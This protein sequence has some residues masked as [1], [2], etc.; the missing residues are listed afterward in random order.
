MV[1]VASKDLGGHGWRGGREGHLIVGGETHVLQ[2]L[3]IA[4][5]QTWPMAMTESSAAMRQPDLPPGG[6]RARRL[7]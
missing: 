5:A 4:P 2:T 3:H 1:K 6:G 7:T